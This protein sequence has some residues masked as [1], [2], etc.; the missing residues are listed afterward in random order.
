MAKKQE[1]V[2][3]LNVLE[4]IDRYPVFTQTGFCVYRKNRKVE[5]T[6]IFGFLRILLGDNGFTIS[7]LPT[8]CKFEN[9]FPAKA[10]NYQFLYD[11]FKIYSP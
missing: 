10:Q 11:G 7:V 9:Y 6:E 8:I 5:G 3:Y 4:A 1:D 2:S